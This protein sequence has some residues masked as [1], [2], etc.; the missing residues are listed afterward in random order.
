MRQSFPFEWNVVAKYHTILCILSNYTAEITLL[1]QSICARF[2][3]EE[4][5][6]P[7]ECGDIPS[8]VSPKSRNVVWV[9]KAS[10]I[11]RKACKK[12]FGRERRA[13][14][15]GLSEQWKSKIEIRIQK[16]ASFIF[17]TVK[18]YVGYFTEIL[19]QILTKLCIALPL[20]LQKIVEFV[21]RPRDIEIEIYLNQDIL[22]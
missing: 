22:F 6:P 10:T 14:T 3:W 16:K 19:E 9:Q 5:I 20:A 8:Q 1:L 12:N 2:P 7:D 17:R 15:W 18:S 11:S 21:W 13:A 4:I